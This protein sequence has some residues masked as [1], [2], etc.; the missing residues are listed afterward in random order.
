MFMI[1]K[2]FS[3]YTVQNM[4]Y[5]KISILGLFCLFGF[6]PIFSQNTAAFLN[7]STAKMIK[8]VAANLDYEIPMLDAAK[9][10]LKASLPELKNPHVDLNLLNLVESKIG[11]H[12]LFEQ[13]FKGIP[14]YRSTVKVNVN[15]E[16]KVLSILSS[17]VNSL[18]FEDLTYSISV[19]E[20]FK[21]WFYDGEKLTEAVK[22][23]YKDSYNIAYE[24]IQNKG[25]DVLNTKMLDLFFDKRDTIVAVK[26]FNPD[27][28]SSAQKNYGDD[29][30]LWKDKFGVDFPEI[31]AQRQDLWMTISISND[32]FYMESRFAKIK[33]LETPILEPYVTL[34]PDF[35]FTRSFSQ[36]KEEMCLFHVEQYQKYLHQIGFDSLA[37]YQLPIDA[38][39]FQGLDQSRFSFADNNP[40]LYFG[41][42]GVEDAEDADVIVHEYTHAVGFSI[43]PNTTNGNERLA[44][45]EANCDFMACQYSKVLSL[46]K[47]REVFNWDG[48]NEFWAGRN[49]G[50]SKRYPNDL[51]TDFYMSSEIWSSLLNDLSVDLG[52]DIV[53]KLFLTSLYSY[54]NNMSMQQAADL[55]VEADSLIFDK[56]HFG[57]LKYYLSERG[58]DVNVGIHEFNISQNIR[59]LNSLGFAKSESNLIIN[60]DL[61]GTLVLE[62][63][64]ISGRKIFSKPFNKSVEISPDELSSGIYIFSISGN[65]GA[66]SYKV[67]KY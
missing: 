45:E 31:N 53:T 7:E 17:L 67:L 6:S 55:L 61:N 44:V 30:G 34:N 66:A 50:T 49:A 48:H 51:S 42:G 41:T 5:K 21:L 54:S 13:T 23:F 2:T 9:Q 14:V 57:V 56:Q 63:T 3:K 52:R 16:G 33:D 15:K 58:F 18:Q 37:N 39:A 38:H 46:Y 25:G 10:F 4:G 62:I 27:P 8:P 1:K 22:T 32:T 20:N 35:V 24:R 29:G 47:W 11:F 36:F 40:S 59:I 60:S 43:A 65:Q 19:S 26:L 64:D 12:F 28:L